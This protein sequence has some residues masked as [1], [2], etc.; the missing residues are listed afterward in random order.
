MQ[1]I[2]YLNHQFVPLEEARISPLDRGFL[3]GDGVYEVIPSYA[4][5]FVGFR[6]HIERLQRN[7]MALDISLACSVEQWHVIANELL[8]K[9]DGDN[10]GV[11]IHVSRG[12]DV[13]RFHGYEH[14]LTPT[15]FAY[16]YEITPPKV[17][18]KDN[19]SGLSVVTQEDT[20]WRQCDIKSTALLGHVMHFQHAYSHDVAETILYNSHGQVTE[21]STSN[22]FIIKDQKV[23]T[24]PL[25]NQLL[26]GITRHIVLDILRTKTD[27]D[28]EE[29]S[30]SLGDLRT[31]DEV[32]LTSAS[33]EIAPVTKIDD[34]AVA[35]GQVGDIWQRVMSLYKQH[36]FYY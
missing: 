5:Q 9:N 31:A 2:A 21:A 32:W 33:K 27:Y 8:S 22:V 23:V 7:L 16:A 35:N 30:I 26:P 24:P 4:G 36:K 1:Q 13:R 28:V 11:Y 29:T 25:D 12:A 20:R 14:G 17:A 34:F 10:L 19:V 3:F 6:L 18:D 15:V